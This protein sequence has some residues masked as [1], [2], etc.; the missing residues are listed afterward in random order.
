MFRNGCPASGLGVRQPSELR[1]NVKSKSRARKYRSS[2]G[3]GRAVSGFGD[4]QFFGIVGRPQAVA[5]IREIALGQCGGRN[6]PRLPEP[7]FAR[8]R[9]YLAKREEAQ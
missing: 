7:R 9:K 6:V 3:R 4:Q 5:A 8:Q 2:T 1:P